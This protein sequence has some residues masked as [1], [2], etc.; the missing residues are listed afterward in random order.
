MT[1][2]G[3]QF[4]DRHTGPG[5]VALFRRPDGGLSPPAFY[6]LKV[7]KGTK[8]YQAQRNLALRQIATDACKRRERFAGPQVVEC[9]ELAP[10]GVVTQ[11][12]MLPFRRQ[13]L[14]D[15][16]ERLGKL[17]KD[18]VEDAGLVEEG[19]LV[20]KH[21]RPNTEDGRQ[22]W[23]WSVVVIVE[24]VAAGAE[25]DLLERNPAQTNKKKKIWV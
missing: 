21:L 6:P 11:D 24:E 16:E 10:D 13:A 25:K 14:L 5:L 7:E 9:W 12:L 20:K 3:D 22:S 4:Y 1:R 2:V 17:V 8:H 19:L 18:V 23:A 15:C